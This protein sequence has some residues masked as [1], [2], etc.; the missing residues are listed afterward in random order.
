MASLFS[1]NCPCYIVQAGCWIH[2]YPEIP[3]YSLTSAFQVLGEQ[4]F[5][6]PLGWT[7]PFIFSEEL[8]CCT[9]IFIAF[10]PFRIYSFPHYPPLHAHG[11][12]NIQVQGDNLISLRYRFI[13]TIFLISLAIEFH[14]ILVIHKTPLIFY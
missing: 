2:L 13:A 10:K 1:L 4:A 8:L 5:A 3:I 9:S 14:K 7:R 6:T 11:I 12:S